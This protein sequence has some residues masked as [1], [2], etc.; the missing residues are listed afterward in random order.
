MTKK[1]RQKFKY[2]ENEKTFEDEIKSI[3]DQIWSGFIET[4]KTIFFEG[5]S[6]T[7]NKENQH[8]MN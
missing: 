1:S 3:F 7:L 5:E 2:I 6:S 8:K 4:N